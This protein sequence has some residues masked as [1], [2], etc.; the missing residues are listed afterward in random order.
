VGY[1]QFV[2]D[3]PCDVCGSFKH[4]DHPGCSYCGSSRHVEHPVCHE[5]G[6]YTHEVHPVPRCGYCGSY[7][8]D[9]HPRC[10]E[11]GDYDHAVHPRCPVC[12]DDTHTDHEE[13]YLKDSDASVAMYWTTLRVFT[14]KLSALLD[15]LENDVTWTTEKIDRW[16]DFGS[17]SEAESGDAPRF[18]VTDRWALGLHCATNT[19]AALLKVASNFDTRFEKTIAR[20]NMGES[21]RLLFARDL[22]ALSGGLLGDFDATQASDS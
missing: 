10:R 20:D 5:C 4:A 6:S 1:K 11:C 7:D 12:G 16:A 2:E 3:M 13:D 17:G 14:K 15:E 19:L 21:K 9:D 8:H 18:V 22:L